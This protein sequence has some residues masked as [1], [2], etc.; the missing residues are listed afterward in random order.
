MTSSTWLTG[1]ATGALLL[2]LAGPARAQDAGLAGV[3]EARSDATRPGVLIYD[4]LFFADIQPRTALDMVER[5]PAFG[6]SNGSSNTRGLAG[7]SGNVLIN[8]R[9][10]S[11]KS[12]GVDTLLE[13]IPAESVDY[14]EVITGGA[15]G[16]DMQGRAVVANVVLKATVTVERVIGLDTYIYDDGYLGPILTAQ[17]SRRAGDNLIEGAISATTDRTSGTSQGRRQRFSP[18]GVLIQD[19]EVDS[20]DRYRNI[21]AS[22]AIQRPQA[23]GLLRVNALVSLYDSDREQ[24][25]F[26]LS[27][28]GDD[29]VSQEA[30]ESLSGEL[31]A[32]WT[33]PLG[34]AS[35]LELTA[36]QRLE[37]SEYQSGFIRTGRTGVFSGDTTEGE[38]IGRVVVRHRRNDR[39]SWEGGGEVA[40]NFL[41]TDSA[42][43][44]NGVPVA[45]PGAS[46][47]VEELRGEVFGQTTWRPDPRLTV[48]GGLRVEASEIRQS[49]D[50]DTSKTLVYPKPRVLVTWTPA[51]SHQFRFRI[52][53]EVGQLDF[54]DFAASA[55]VDLGQVE[56]GNA[57]LEPEK[58]TYYEAIY[59]RRFWE[60]GSVSARLTHAVIE[61]YIDIIP[62]V[63]GF[64]ALGNIGTGTQ[65][66]FEVRTTLPL[67]RLGVPG[68]RLIA[69]VAHRETEIEDPLTGETH[70][71]SGDDGFGCGVT[72]TQDLDGGRWSWGGN[73]G[74]DMDAG[75]S[76]RIREVR[77]T[78]NEPQ[79]NLFVQW[80]PTPDLT[81][82]VDAANL[83]D[84]EQWR[85]RDIYSG[86]RNTAPLSYR[87]TYS[88]TRGSWLFL[89][90]RKT[91]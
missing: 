67:D 3:A 26:I 86:P 51:P 79:F 39:W 61:D 6:I 82:R 16:I 30:N 80:K 11:N 63:G 25:V 28:A 47:L 12:E 33:R 60:E 42:Y 15:P 59:E 53:R 21:R 87:E 13:R 72:F 46:V 14:I 32:R 91:L 41:D 49:G 69:R 29:D 85:Q 75:T 74:C 4:P 62:L 34:D 36:L 65:T 64:E 50:T 45:L 8:G 52:E 22:G 9:H 48:E 10:P 71:F 24:D 23:G 68:G 77:F 88:Q 84:M 40:Y 70:R 31:G 58:T 43:E 7:T 56:A 83:T 27:G 81:L 5:L 44:E 89:Q 38:S 90:I 57:D 73:H 2:A 78:D 35:E 18:S 20:W 1:A 55:E 76:Y 19:A 17:Y 37:Q 54:D 66:E